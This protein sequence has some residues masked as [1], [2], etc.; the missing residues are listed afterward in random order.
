MIEKKV[1]ELVESYKALPNDYQGIS[2][3]ID[4]RK[5]LSISLV[6]LANETGEARA[7]W[8]SSAINYE[9]EKN[10]LRIDYISDGTQKADWKAR[11]NTTSVLKKMTENENDFYSKDYLLRYCRDLLGEMSQRIAIAREEYK[12]SNFNG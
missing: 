8:K 1:L 10:A 6:Y 7:N 12:E 11:A 2:E 9:L 3:L 4:L 5:E